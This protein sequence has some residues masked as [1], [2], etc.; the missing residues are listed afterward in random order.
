VLAPFLLSR[1]RMDWM[2][3][4]TRYAPAFATVLFVAAALWIGT[5]FSV[6]WLCG[7]ARMMADGPEIGRLASSL[8]GRWTVPSLLVSLGAGSGLWLAA[9]EH[10]TR[11]LWLYGAVALE[12]ALLT[13]SVRVGRRARRV[14]CSAETTS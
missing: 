3:Q 1:R 4:M 6:S 2:A 12:I 13:V 14:S 11:A 8:F 10:Q 7:R 5:L 9:F